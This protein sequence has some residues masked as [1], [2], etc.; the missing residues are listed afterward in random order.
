MLGLPLSQ[1]PPNPDSGST[2][3]GERDG[4]STSHRGA[5]AS[6]LEV[7]HICTFTQATNLEEL[8]ANPNIVDLRSYI[9]LTLPPSRL[10]PRW[11]RIA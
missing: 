10:H 4:L 11:R 9:Y 1:L 3:A 7:T 8:L 6:Y 5:A 2:K